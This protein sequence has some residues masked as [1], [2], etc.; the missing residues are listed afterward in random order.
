M[1]SEEIRTMAMGFQSSRILLSAIDLELFT[2][3]G[4][5]ALSAGQIAAKAGTNERATDRLLNALCNLGFLSKENGL[6]MN[7]PDSL[8]YLV[9]TSPEYMG[10]LAH[11]SGMFY[12]WSGMTEAVKAGKSVEMAGSGQR[13]VLNLEAFIGAMHY[14]AKDTALQLVKGIPLDNVRNLLDV[15]GGSGVFSMAFCELNPN[16]YATVVDLPAVIPITRRYITDSKYSERIISLPLNYLTEPV[17]GRWDIIFLSAI[18]H[19]HSNETNAMLMK[20]F[21][22]NLNPGGSIVIHD[23]VMSSDRLKP[24]SGAFFALN[25]LCGTEEGDTF[26]RE[27]ME[28]WLT[29][30]GLEVEDP[31]V[32]PGGQARISGRKPRG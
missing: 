13:G 20:T 31:M 1:T 17:P 6:F 5:H 11:M 2:I 12:K 19:M 8:K 30:A 23:F 29:D 21:A 22:G 3:V 27:E 28:K 10:G 18:V 16:I 32:L 9:R 26:T 4:N 24:E 14:R 15:G 7:A 25:M